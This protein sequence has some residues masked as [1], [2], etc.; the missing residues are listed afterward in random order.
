MQREHTMKIEDCKTCGLH[1]R[2]DKIRLCKSCHYALKKARRE[3]VGS[4]A[5]YKRK[6]NSLTQRAKIG[7]KTFELSFFECNVLKNKMSLLQIK[8]IY[9]LGKQRGL[10]SR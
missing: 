7:N 8:N 9:S 6:F 10:I 4:R 3:A 1:P 5:W 2:M